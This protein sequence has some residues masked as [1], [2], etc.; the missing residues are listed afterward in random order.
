[1]IKLLVGC[2]LITMMM[3]GCALPVKNEIKHEVII[4][5]VREL[6]HLDFKTINKVAIADMDNPKIQELLDSVKY[7]QKSTSQEDREFY[8]DKVLNLLKE[9]LEV[10]DEAKS[11]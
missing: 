7:Y 3:V 10:N 1:M 11:N 5:E 4:E 8:H 2:I 9:I 6:P